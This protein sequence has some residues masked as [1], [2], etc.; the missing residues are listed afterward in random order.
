MIDNNNLLMF[1]TASTLL[2]FAPGPDNIF[3]LT[4]SMI[5]G[6]N[7]GFKIT[8]GLCTGLVVHTLLVVVGIS[9]I[10]K[11]SLIAFNI[12]KYIG[13]VLFIISFMEGLYCSSQF[14]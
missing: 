9:A 4:Q 5:R 2:G 6:R 7:A 8:L 3:V 12:L 13:V 1:L 14:N 11:T 10:F